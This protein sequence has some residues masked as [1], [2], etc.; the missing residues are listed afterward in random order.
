VFDQFFG[1]AMEQADVR[2]DAPNHFTIEFQHKPQYPM[3]RRV[4]RSKIDCE[5]A[6]R[7]FGHAGSFRCRLGGELR[8]VS[9]VPTDAPKMG[10]RK[11]TQEMRRVESPT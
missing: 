5:I 3:R 6:E 11:K 7:S 10:K 9:S 1:A 2:V 8:L 4:L